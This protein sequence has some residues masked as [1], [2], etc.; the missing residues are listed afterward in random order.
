MLTGMGRD[1]APEMLELKNAGAETITQSGRSCVVDGMPRAARTLGASTIDV[2][3]EDIGTAILD[4][5]AKANERSA[6]A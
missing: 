2:D 6:N 3:L 5:C 1:G 4:A